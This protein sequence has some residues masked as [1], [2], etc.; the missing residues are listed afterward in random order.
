[1]PTMQFNP[2]GDVIDSF[3]L[4]ANTFSEER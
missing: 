2:V 4:F 3:K 1:L